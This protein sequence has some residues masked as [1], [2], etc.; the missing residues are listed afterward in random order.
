MASKV[1]MVDQRVQMNSGEDMCLTDRHDLKLVQTNSF[2]TLALGLADRP[3]LCGP[4]NMRSQVKQAL[5]WGPKT[6]E[7][8][9]AEPANG[10][11][12]PTHLNTWRSLGTAGVYLQPFRRY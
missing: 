1:P 9:I 3:D 5:F 4:R 12:S 10:V 2:S 11:L 8:K 6:R 7:S